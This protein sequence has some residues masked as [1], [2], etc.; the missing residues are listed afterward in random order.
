MVLGG[1]RNPK[2]MEGSRICLSDSYSNTTSSFLISFINSD[3]WSLNKTFADLQ[4]RRGLSA[5]EGRRVRG[6]KMHHEND[7]IQIFTG[8]LIGVYSPALANMKPSA[9]V[10]IWCLLVF[11]LYIFVIAI[12]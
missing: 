11:F 5:D 8:T 2:V 1:E 4:I 12:D 9:Q 7:E 10:L 6:T 3:L